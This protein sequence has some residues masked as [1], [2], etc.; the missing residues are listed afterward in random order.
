MPFQSV[1]ESYSSFY[2]YFIQKPQETE[3]KL[4]DE[5]QNEKEKGQCSIRR[6]Q[7]KPEKRQHQVGRKQN[8]EEKNQTDRGMEMGGYGKAYDERRMY[9]RVRGTRRY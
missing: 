3:A 9:F 8:Q 5:R 6:E 1:I 7:H 2:S 4:D